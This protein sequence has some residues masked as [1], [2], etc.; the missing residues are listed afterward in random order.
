[1]LVLPSAMGADLKQGSLTVLCTWKGKKL[2]WQISWKGNKCLTCS[3]GRIC[4]AQQE[5]VLK[6]LSGEG[7]ALEYWDCLPSLTVNFR[8]LCKGTLT[9]QNLTCQCHLCAS[10]LMQINMRNVHMQQPLLGQEFSSESI[11]LCGPWLEP[12]EATAILHH[13]GWEPLLM[14]WVYQRIV[15]E[16]HWVYWAWKQLGQGK[17]MGIEQVCL[18]ERLKWQN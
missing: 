10:S 5:K 12:S 3:I 13:L 9:P 4:C 18:A 14:M 2:W 6:G 17:I 16:G 15:G 1:M 11:C 8:L 7:L